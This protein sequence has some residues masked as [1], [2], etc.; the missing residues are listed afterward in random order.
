MRAPCCPVA[1]FPASR[2]G[3]AQAGQPARPS[4]EEHRG[5]D[6]LRRAGRH[7]AGQPARRLHGQ[8]LRRRLRHR[9]QDPRHPLPDLQ[10]ARAPRS[11]ASCTWSTGD[12]LLIGPER[13]KDIRTSRARGQ[14]ALVPEQ[15]SRARSRSAGAEDER[16]GGD[17]EE[18]PEDRLFRDQRPESPDCRRAPR[19]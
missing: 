2:P 13:F 9:P 17:L 6:A 18:E 11:C 1:D 4:A 14:R 16:G 12:Y 3:P 8:E 7:L 10:R 15:A 5:A 19:G